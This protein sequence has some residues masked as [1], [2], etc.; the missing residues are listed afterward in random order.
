MTQN[1]R[2]Q[3]NQQLMKLIVTSG[4]VTSTVMQLLDSS[5]ELTFQEKWEQLDKAKQM[6]VEAH[7][8]QTNLIQAEVRGEPTPI[9]LLAIHAQDHFMNSQLLVQIAE[10]LLKQQEQIEALTDK[11]KGVGE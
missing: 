1:I 5:S 9:S 7:N 2:K 11:L 6:N 8:V 4:K 10:M 3:F